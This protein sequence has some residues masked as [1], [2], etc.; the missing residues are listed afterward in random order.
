[1]MQR[2][3]LQFRTMNMFDSFR[4]TKGVLHPLYLCNTY[5]LHFATPVHTPS[6]QRVRHWVVNSRSHWVLYIILLLPWCWEMCG[7]TNPRS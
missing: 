2:I 1:M 6:L 5:S 4:I 3:D 7:Y